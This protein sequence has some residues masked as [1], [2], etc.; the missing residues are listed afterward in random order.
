M[1]GLVLVFSFSLSHGP[2]TFNKY[3]FFL[4]FFPIYVPPEI[5]HTGTLTTY[6]IKFLAAGPNLLLIIRCISP[7]YARASP[8]LYSSVAFHFSNAIFY[9]PFY[10]SSPMPQ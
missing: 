3:Y 10:F 6:I 4:S 2:V 1:I 7:L 8:S 5:I 9:H